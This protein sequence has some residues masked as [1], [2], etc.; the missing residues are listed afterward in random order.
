[1]DETQPL[2]PPSEAVLAAQHEHDS[3]PSIVAFDPKGDDENPL[4]WPVAYKWGIVG[5]LAFVAF[6]VTFTCISVVPV[7]S[8]IVADLS[9]RPSKSASV[10]LV[11]IWELGEAAGPLLI[12]PLSEIYGRYPVFNAANLLFIVGVALAALSQ[13]TGLLI[14]ARF[15]TGMAVASNVLNPAIVGDIFP[16][17]SRGSA[18][19]LMM[20]A[21]LIGGAVGPAIAGAIAQST[22]WRQIMWMSIILATVCEVCF[23]TLFRETYQVAILRRRAARL[24]EERQDETLKTAFDGKGGKGAESVIWTAIARPARVFSSSFVL[25]ILSLYGAVIFSFFYV[26]STTLPEI[27]QNEYHMPPALIGS[28]FLSF[29]VGSMIGVIVCNTAIDRISTH[30]QHHGAHADGTPQP[31]NRLPLVILGAFALPLTVTLY[32]WAASAHWPVSVLILSVALMGFAVTLA[33]VPVTAYVVDAFGLYAASALTAVLIA[34]C[35]MSTVLPLATAPLTARLG[36]GFGF[37][38]LAA[39][40]LVIAPIPVVVMRYGRRWR[41]ASEYTKDGG[42]AK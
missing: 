19:S 36:Y 9:G 11:T 17:E 32:G 4:D 39:V 6:T 22:G 33:I 41:Q 2:L 26:M 31:E 13:S 25:Q 5:L 10:L 35:L 28:S 20:L 34:R 21:P 29:S 7:A 27:L 15:L 14:F 1:M 16:T 42:V 38:V 3:D 23:L 40:C 30:L 12:A 18:M 8:H 37:M 24:R